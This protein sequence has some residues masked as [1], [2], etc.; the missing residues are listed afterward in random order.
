[1]S[2][3]PESFLRGQIN[4]RDLG[5]IRA[6]GGRTVKKHKLI[7]SGELSR[8]TEADLEKLTHIRL[9]AVVDLRS[10]SELALKK[11]RLPDGVRFVHCPVVSD[12]IPGITRE[13]V[14]DPYDGLKRADYA[15]DLREGGMA[16]MRSLYPI[17]VESENAVQQYRRFFDCVL[18]NGDGAVL[19][20]CAM[21]K[22]RAGVAAALLLYALGASREDIMRDYMYTALVCAEK[23]RSDTDACR[24]LTNDEELLESIYWL[25]TT[26]ES[27]LDA[28][29]RSCTEQCGSV[30]RYLAE[31][32]G[33]TQ[34]KLSQLRTMYLE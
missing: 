3:L 6:A 1:M 11:D 32:L 16:K 4:A 13:S 15:R 30:E 23:I 22:D 12:L 17:L 10:P 24:E 2:Y 20:H 26:H 29:F 5:G 33:L 34:N 31:K 25:N 9:S 8:L 28:M 27:Y 7:R 14:E 19:F 18:A 21:G